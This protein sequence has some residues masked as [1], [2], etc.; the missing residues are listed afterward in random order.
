[1][2]NPK[3]LATKGT[4]DEEKQTKKHNTKKNGQHYAQTNTN[5]IN[6][7]WALLQTSGGEDK[8]NIVLYH[9]NNNN[10]FTSKAHKYYSSYIDNTNRKQHDI[11]YNRKI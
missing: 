5:K 1:M 7:T 11:M 2:D 8:P 10:M 6:K 9:N 4:Q 3:K